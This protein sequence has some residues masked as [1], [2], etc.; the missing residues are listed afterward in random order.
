MKRKRF[1]RQYGITML[2]G[3]VLG[4]GVFAARQGFSLSAWPEIAAALCDACFVPAALLIGVGLLL[5]VSNDGLFY[6]MSYGVQRA[7]RLILSARKQAEF[8]KS[9]YEYWEL[10]Q[11]AGKAT[12]GYI[13][14]AGLTL[15]ALATVFLFASGT[16]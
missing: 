9:Y 8:P 14:A 2:V 1:F 15:L 10:K 7:A 3:L 6:M 5:F 13:I 4:V 12:F 11:A 16:I